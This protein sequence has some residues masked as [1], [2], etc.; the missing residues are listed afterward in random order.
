MR[1]E[2]EKF[3]LTQVQFTK[4]YDFYIKSSILKDFF[5]GLALSPA[6]NG[7]AKR[8]RLVTTFSVY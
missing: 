1:I 2:L 7:T 5:N 8:G 3:S 4:F 6:S